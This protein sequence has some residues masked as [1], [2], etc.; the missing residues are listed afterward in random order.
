[1]Q[2]DA[3]SPGTPVEHGFHGAPEVRRTA[4]MLRQFARDS[5]IYGSTGVMSAIVSVALLPLYTRALTPAEY[6]VIDMLTVLAAIVNVTIALEIWH[7]V[8]R[9]Y[10]DIPDEAGKVACA[11][12]GLW[13]T[14]LSYGV[15]FVAILGMSRTVS[16]WLLDGEARQPVLLL[17]V[18]SLWLWAVTFFSQNLLRIQLKPVLHAVSTCLVLLASTTL[19]VYLVVGCGWG[20]AGLY[21]GSILGYA[22]G[23]LFSL[24]A[25]RRSYR[26]VFDRRKW[27]AMVGYSLPLMLSSLG[28]V[29]LIYVDRVVIKEALSMDDLGVYGVAYRFASGFGLIAVMFQASLGPMI[30]SRHSQP[31]TPSDFA[32]VF[33]YAIAVLLSAFVA[34]SILAKEVVS[35]FTAPSFWGAADLL[36][37]LI[38]SAILSSGMYIFAP[39]LLIA[40]RTKRFAA[41]MLISAVLNLLL[42]LVLV[43]SIGTIGAAIASISGF[44]CWFAMNMLESQRAYPVPHQWPR[45]FLG[46]LAAIVGVAVHVVSSHGW[47]GE[48]LR[49]GLASR[50]LIIMLTCGAIWLLTVGPA[51]L[52]TTLTNL[53]RTP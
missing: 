27:G 33:K 38:P 16:L 14:A 29:A 44:G 26:L 43:P 1:M 47:M 5:A 15:F 20:L 2:M 36:P 21:L 22:V 24:W 6:G 17:S 52:R 48:E 40:K 34:G 23:G 19:A 45:L 32:R 53:I 3:L 10:P 18:V 12:T 37:F 49:L 41:I 51:E 8:G 35:L 11:S 4:T 28:S 30:M 50:M 7:A 42:N 13:F 46:L 9:F 39:G 31:G 25:T